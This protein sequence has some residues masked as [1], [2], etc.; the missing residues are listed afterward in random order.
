MVAQGRQVLVP[1]DYELWVMGSRFRWVE[2]R[3]FR[4]VAQ[5]TTELDVEVEPAV[6]RRLAL[7]GLPPDAAAAGTTCEIT[8]L[9]DGEVHGRFS[10]QNDAL[11]TLGG[12][13][14]LG[15]YEV[16]ILRNGE[17]WTGRFR[18]ET[19]APR[20]DQVR[21]PVSRAPDARSR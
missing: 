15:A 21:V 17:R 4:V 16:A 7:D 10:L 20:F 2:G 3:P 19:L 13:W 5:Q 9:D 18:V 11:P 12:T 8:A 6:L 1:G 14:P